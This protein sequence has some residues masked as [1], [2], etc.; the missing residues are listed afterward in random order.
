MTSAF[1]KARIAGLSPWF[2]P[3]RL[4][5]RHG[6]HF[7]LWCHPL[8]ISAPHSTPNELLLAAVTMFSEEHVAAW[9]LAPAAVERQHAISHCLGK[10]KIRT[11]NIMACGM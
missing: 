10:T 4:R 1:C 11:S 7:A 5:H 9:S 6:I 3:V 8:Y 2:A